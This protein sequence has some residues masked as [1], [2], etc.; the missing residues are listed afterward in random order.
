MEVKNRNS[1]VGWGGGLGC[2]EQ[3]DW[4]RG[5]R[6]RTREREREVLESDVG[7]ERRGASSG[8]L[9]CSDYK[10]GGVPAGG[11]NS[12]SKQVGTHFC[13]FGRQQDMFHHFFFFFFWWRGG[14]FGKRSLKAEV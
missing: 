5:R 2:D 10:Q 1:G 6:D 14:F 11:V 4:E 3:M 7:D 9:V 12:S 13:F 8:R